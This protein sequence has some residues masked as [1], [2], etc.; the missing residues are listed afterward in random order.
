MLNW[1]FKDNDA[2]QPT[3]YAKALG[4]ITFKE[5]ANV[6]I[7]HTDRENYDDKSL[8]NEVF[9]VFNNE[10]GTTS[11]E[12]GAN[13]IVKGKEEDGIVSAIASASSLGILDPLKQGR[14][15][16]NASHDSSSITRIW[17][18]SDN[19]N[20]E[21]NFVKVFNENINAYTFSQ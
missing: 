14:I 4:V 20:D 12:N 11:F 3:E 15:E 19:D 2:K 6:S 5:F 17:G 8:E 1:L 10:G 13:I 9:A 21:E 7:T 16:V 18:L